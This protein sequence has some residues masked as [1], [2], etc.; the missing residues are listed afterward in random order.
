[1]PAPKKMEAIELP[2]WSEA[3]PKT[4]PCLRGLTFREDRQ[5][6]ARLQALQGQLDVREGYDGIEIR[7]TSFVGQID[8]GVLRISIKPKL[9][10]LPLAR[11]LAYAYGLRDLAF[12]GTTESPLERWGLQEV[13]IDLI[14]IELEELTYSGLARR[15]VPANEFLS[16][17]RGRIQV[18]KIIRRG[19]IVDASLPCEF[20]NRNS[21]WHLNRVLRSGALLAANLTGQP[22]LKLRLRRTAAFFN[23][24]QILS[25]LHKEHLS[26][27][28]RE[29]T[30]ITE[31]S[32]SVLYLIDLLLD[33]MGVAF[34]SQDRVSQIPG[35]LFDMNLFFQRLLSRF[36]RDNLPPSSVAD[37]RPIRNIF[38]Y[39]REPHAAVR[40]VPNPRPD[41]AVYQGKHLRGF[42]DAKYRD[43]WDRGL[44]ANWLYQ[45]SI[46]ALASPCETAVLLYPSMSDETVPEKIVLRHPA[47]TIDQRLASVVMRPVHLLLMAELVHPA[48]RSLKQYARRQFAESLI[49]PLTRC[50]N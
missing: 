41:Y 46:Y 22:Q 21:D 31:S 7:S 39:E 10:N 6:R 45:L 5:S 36:L 13:L 50:F 11:L 28:I 26:R 48:H 32:R 49:D 37:E 33:G 9:H 19:G 29:L 16:S 3:T 8:I 23:D 24:V 38:E 34:T 27:A 2:E 25:G 42:M 47:R 1:M 43:I 17:P 14:S 30:R 15:Y 40:S 35:F 4:H 18:S 20:F 44:P 12:I